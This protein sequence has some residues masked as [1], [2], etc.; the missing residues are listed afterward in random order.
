MVRR[1]AVSQWLESVSE[2]AVEL[3]TAQVFKSGDP[4][5]IHKE[6]YLDGILSLLSGHQTLRACQKAQ[7]YGRLQLIFYGVHFS[8]LSF[9]TVVLM[10]FSLP[11]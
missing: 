2:T 3:E 4:M 10:S 11:R 8:Q 6:E 5:Y 9:L 7:E 1:K